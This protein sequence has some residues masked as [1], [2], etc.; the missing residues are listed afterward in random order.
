MKSTTRQAE[1]QD[2]AE[3]VQVARDRQ[4]QQWSR[5]AYSPRK[6]LDGVE[7]D[8]DVSVLL[9]FGSWERHFVD[10]SW[11]TRERKIPAIMAMW[12]IRE[13]IDRARAVR[14]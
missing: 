13:L 10:A 3:V 1:K 9:N 8:G 12:D 4:R 14:R 5:E 7:A 2:A 6:H 11:P